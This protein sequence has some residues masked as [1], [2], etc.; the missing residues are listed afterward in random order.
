MAL[1]VVAS[2]RSA[3]R[4]GLC[5]AFA[6]GAAILM[7]LPQGAN[8]GFVINLS[9]SG[10][11]LDTV[12][13]GFDSIVTGLQ[14]FGFTAP[15]G[16]THL[17]TAPQS[18]TVGTTTFSNTSP[19]TLFLN[20]DGKFFT[21]AYLESQSPAPAAGNDVLTL[22]LGSKQDAIGVN[23]GNRNSGTNI[24]GTKFMFAVNTI[25]GSFTDTVTFGDG[26]A[27]DPRFFLGFVGTS[28]ISSVTV[29]SE[30]ITPTSTSADNIDITAFR[31]ADPVPEP[32]SLAILGTGLIAL[33]AARRR[34]SR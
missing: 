19:D 5:I 10:T 1:T 2:N 28:Q 18:T 12:D 23:F 31:L 17:L 8:A 25:G 11:N 9:P 13:T 3:A 27:S 30:P 29:T 24:N 4:R 33:A 6:L 26:I 20:N 16:T 32:A 21:G 34:R 15:A 22:T 7:T 14:D